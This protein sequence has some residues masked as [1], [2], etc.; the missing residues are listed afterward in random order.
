MRE[1]SLKGSQIG[2]TVFFLGD[3]SFLTPA[4]IPF[5]IPCISRWQEK[6]P[7]L[8]L[9]N[10]EHGLDVANVH[11]CGKLKGPDACTTWLRA[12]GVCTMQ[13]LWLPD[14]QGGE[15]RQ[16]SRGAGHASVA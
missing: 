14:L 12:S 8:L 4:V 1:D 2:W 9:D 6:A 16:G 5:L 13:L 11:P 10:L 3:L 7:W 15:G